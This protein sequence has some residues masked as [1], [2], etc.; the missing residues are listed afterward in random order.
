MLDRL[1]TV[2]AVVTCLAIASCGAKTSSNAAA[3]SPVV[4]TVAGDAI[5]AADLRVEEGNF[6]S[7]AQPTTPEAD[8]AALQRIIDRKLL[9]KAALAGKLDQAKTFAIETRRAQESAQATALARQLSAQRPP[10]SPEQVNKF[11]ADNPQAF[12]DRKILVIEQIRMKK[13]AQPLKDAAD[14]EVN[15]LAEIQA[16][17]E[18]GRLTYRRT[19]NVIDSA[20]T[21]PEILDHLKSFAPHAMFEV[22][23]GEY[24]TVNEVLAIHPAPL[25]GA[26]AT[27][28][29]TSALRAQS[30]DEALQAKIRSLRDAAKKDIRYTAGYEPAEKPKA[31]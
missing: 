11:I 19:V 17:A 4:A 23:D 1:R 31:P 21:D 8:Q 12:R 16:A 9:A 22:V 27:E 14:H 26:G 5:T 3:G 6:Q 25:S 10:P 24:L 2:G 7:G 18:R 20:E 13:P 30:A 29:A 15:T 28:A